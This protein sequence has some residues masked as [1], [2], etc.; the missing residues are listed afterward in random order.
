MLLD[1]AG[2]CRVKLDRVQPKRPNS[3]RLSV[4]ANSLNFFNGS[5]RYTPEQVLEHINQSRLTRGKPLADLDQEAIGDEEVVEFLA[6]HGQGVIF[7]EIEGRKY[8]NWDL[9]VELISSNFIVV[10]DH[11]L[12]Y[13]DPTKRGPNTFSYIPPELLYRLMNDEQFSYQT[14][15]DFQDFIIRLYGDIG[16]GHV[17]IV[18]D[19][20]NIEGTDCIVFANLASYG[21][22]YPVAIPWNLYCNYLAYDW[23]NGRGSFMRDISDLPNEEMLEQIKETGYLERGNME[24]FYGCFE[25]YFPQERQTELDAILKKYN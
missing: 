7:R 19:L 20:K 24:Y 22:E 12:L 11:Q 25:I 15:L 18:V 3:C 14:F 23:G 21:N 2:E 17:D 6:N 8:L 4:A 5:Q 13:C 16:N 1:Y 10:A 9:L